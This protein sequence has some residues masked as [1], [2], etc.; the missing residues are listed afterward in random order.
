MYYLQLSIIDMVFTFHAL[1]LTNE[2]INSCKLA[3]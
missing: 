3:P 2:R 1:P